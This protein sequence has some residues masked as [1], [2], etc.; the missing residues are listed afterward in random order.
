LV[1][2]LLIAGYPRLVSFGLTGGLAT[3][4][5]TVGIAAFVL[6]PLLAVAAL[7]RRIVS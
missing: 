1:A 5:R 7:V 2:V 3:T 6:A 4:V